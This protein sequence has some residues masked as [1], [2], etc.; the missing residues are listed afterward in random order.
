[1]THLG[2]SRRRRW[3]S[4]GE[5]GGYS[6]GDALL[7]AELRERCKTGQRICQPWISEHSILCAASG[8]RVRYSHF[9]DCCSIPS[10]CPGNLARN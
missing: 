5:K 4:M 1:M 7:N 3:Q 8:S 9:S 10:E 2:R 6:G